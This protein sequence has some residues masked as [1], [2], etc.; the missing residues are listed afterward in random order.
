MRG[1]LLLHFVFIFLFSAFDISYLSHLFRH[2]FTPLLSISFRPFNSNRKTFGVRHWLRSFIFLFL[3][4]NLNLGFQQKRLR[5]NEVYVFDFLIFLYRR[6][7]TT[8]FSRITNIWLVIS[9]SNEGSFCLRCTSSERF[10]SEWTQR[11]MMDHYSLF[12]E[13]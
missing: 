13:F 2:F 6:W 3:F 7:L 11:S 10:A 8:N 12:V 9:K 4:L 1:S 5:S